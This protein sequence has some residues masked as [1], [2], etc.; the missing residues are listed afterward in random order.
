MNKKELF[1]KT[2]K[3]STNK[4]NIVWMMRQAGRFLKN[5]RKMREKHSFLDMCTTPSLAAKA[6]I[7][8]YDEV[9]VDVMILFS[10]ILIPLKSLGAKIYYEENKQPVVDIDME[11]IIYN[12]D[13]LEEIGFVSETV[14]LIKS[15]NDEAG[16]IG[17]AAAPFTL[18]CYMLGGGKDFYKVRSFIYKYPQKFMNI[19]QILTNLTVDYLNMQISS[20]C[21][22]VQLFDSWAG[23]VPVDIYQK[24]IYPFNQKVADSLNAPSIY[25]IKNSAHLNNQIINLNFDCLSLDWR[26]DMYKMSSLSSKCIQGNIDN[27]LLLADKKILKEKIVEIDS[28]M[29]NRAHIFNLGH[30]ILPQTSE[31]MAKFFVD[32]VH[33]AKT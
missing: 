29:K 8:P 19:M 9:G 30:G 12:K 6:T 22:A 3:G 31:D 33:N 27:T 24:F 16:L 18:S 14:K 5:Y 7:M 20:G 1:L 32:T 4:E 23:I 21:D 13:N 26:Q 15:E 2:L 17:F 11:N 28:I 10:D 25:Y